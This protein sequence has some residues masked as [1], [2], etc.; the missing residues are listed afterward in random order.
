VFAVLA[1]SGRSLLCPVPWQ[2][3]E[4]LGCF[5]K[6][7][8]VERSQSVC[9]VIAQGH[10]DHFENEIAGKCGL[11]VLHFS[12]MVLEIEDNVR[13]VPRRSSASLPDVLHARFFRP[14]LLAEALECPSMTDSGKNAT[15]VREGPSG[16]TAMR[17][18]IDCI[19]KLAAPENLSQQARNRKIGIRALAVIGGRHSAWRA[20]LAVGRIRHSS[21]AHLSS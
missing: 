18:G 14:R 11:V 21:H 8:E 7:R 3:R 5:N 2:D 1:R 17:L 20:A 16:R 13:R 4:T 6:R 12:M 19:P 10:P 15:D 9:H